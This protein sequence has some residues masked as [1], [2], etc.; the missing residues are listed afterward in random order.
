M[1]VIERSCHALI[2]TMAVCDIFI[3]GQFL[4]VLT[5]TGQYGKYMLDAKGVGNL[6]MA[7]QSLGD[8]VHDHLWSG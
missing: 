5:G 2:S 6:F 4:V 1:C 7:S 8:P 3:N